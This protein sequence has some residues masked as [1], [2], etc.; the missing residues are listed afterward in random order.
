MNFEWILLA[1]FLVAI[2]SGMSKSLS[3]SMLK[4][5]LRLGAVVLS[6]LVTLVLQLCGVFQGA[7]NAIIEAINLA[8]MLPGFEGAMVLISGIASTLVSPIFFVIVFFVLLW[9]FRII[10]HFVVKSIESKKAVNADAE[11]EIKESPA[12]ISQQKYQ[13]PKM[14][15]PLRNHPLWKSLWQKLL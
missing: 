13:C 14:Q 3:K 10:I 8:Q 4:N 15:S 7:V 1:F 2:I 11:Q 5:T 9:I 12:G 6:F